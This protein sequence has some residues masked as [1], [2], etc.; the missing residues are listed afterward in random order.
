MENIVN[1]AD[2]MS[3]G[4]FKY[5]DLA[6]DGSFNLPAATEGIMLAFISDGTWAMVTWTTAGVPT[7]HLASDMDDV[8]VSS[9][10]GD[11][12]FIDG[13]TYVTIMNRRGSTQ[14]VQLILSYIE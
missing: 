2:S 7:I 13:G 3:R 9:V 10:D 1:I 14:S 5:R 4:V 12:C 6:D 8:A 11:L